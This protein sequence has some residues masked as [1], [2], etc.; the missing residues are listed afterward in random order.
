M[1]STGQHDSKRKECWGHY[2]RG[3][4]RCNECDDRYE[5]W[6]ISGYKIPKADELEEWDEKD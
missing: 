5:C 3:S 1:D 4:Q 2:N 6:K